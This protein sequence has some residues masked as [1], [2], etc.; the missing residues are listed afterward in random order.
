[1]GTLDLTIKNNEKAIHIDT[2]E[3]LLYFMKWKK[4]SVFRTAGK[5][6]GYYECLFVL[7]TGGMWELCWLLNNLQVC[8]VDLHA[9]DKYFSAT[10]SLV[11]ESKHAETKK[12]KNRLSHRE[13][14]DCLEGQHP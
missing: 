6:W 14:F 5:I 4:W 1:M 12:R 13:I 2:E 9:H 8:G 3:S 7:K 11:A 10:W